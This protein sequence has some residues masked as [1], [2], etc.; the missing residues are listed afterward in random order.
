MTNTLGTMLEILNSYPWT[1]LSVRIIG[2]IKRQFFHMVTHFFYNSNLSKEI[3][4]STP[5]ELY[6]LFG[7]WSQ[8]YVYDSSDYMETRL[9]RHG[10]L[11]TAA[12]MVYFVFYL[13]VPI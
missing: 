10:S 1:R 9:K 2:E 12:L 7:T 6:I 5:G 11:F 8:A 3:L 13:I 4:Q